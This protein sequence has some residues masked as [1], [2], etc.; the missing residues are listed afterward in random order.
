MAVT[1]EDKLAFAIRDLIWDAIDKGEIGAGPAVKAVA[2]ALGM[3]GDLYD[4]Q[5]HYVG[6]GVF[7]DAYGRLCNAKRS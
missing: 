6:A 7:D 2:D 1:T 3:I 5:G 4:D